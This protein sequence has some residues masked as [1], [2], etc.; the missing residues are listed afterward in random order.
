MDHTESADAAAQPEPAAPV[1]EPKRSLLASLFG[2]WDPPPWVRWLWGRKF[3]VAGVLA[4]LALVGYGAWWWATRP[5]PVIPNALDVTLT[6]PGKTDYDHDEIRVRPL[7]VHFSGSAAPLADVEGEAQG[8]TLEPFLDGSFRWEDDHTIVFRPAKDWPVGQHYTVTLDP[9][10]TVAETV[11]LAPF[12]L[13]FDTAPFVVEAGTAEFYQDP[14]DAALKKSVWELRFSHPVDAAKFESALRVRL[15]DG[16][17]RVLPPP[18][19][20]TQYNARKLNAWVHSAPLELPPNGGEAHLDVGQGITSALGGPGSTGELSMKVD[21][22]ALYSVSVDDLSPTLVEEPGKEPIQVI[23]LGFNMAMKDREVVGATRAWLLPEKNPKLKDNE[24]T[25][26]YGWS[27]DEVDEA[28][29][30]ASMPLELKADPAE[31]EWTEIH[32]FKYQAPVG[33]RLYVRVNQ[34]L[35]SFGGFI[36]GKP[37]AGVRVVPEFPRMLNFVGEGALLSLRGERRVTVVARNMPKARLEIGRVLPEQLHHLVQFNEGSYGNPELWSIGEDSLVERMEKRIVLPGGDP[38][39]TLYE[40]VDLGEFFTG[41][42]HGVFLLSLRTLSDHEAEQSPDWTIGNDAGETMDARLVVLTDLGIVVKKTLDGSREVFVQ[43]LA[44]GTPVAGARVRVLARNGET[45]AASDTDAMGRASLPNLDGFQREKVAVAISVVAGE[46]LSFLPLHKYDRALDFSRFDIG[47]DANEIDAGTLKAHLFSDRGLYRPGDTVNIGFIVRAADWNRPLAGIPLEVEFSDPRGSVVKRQRVSLD[48]TGFD[49]FSHAP[50]EGAPSGTWQATLYLIGEEDSRTMIGAT[51][52]QIREFLPDTMRVRTTL[53]ASASEGWVKPDGMSATVAVENLFGT[54]AQQ[55]RVEA[56]LLLRPAFPSFARWPGWRF[57][58]PLS[59]NDGVNEPLSEGE[60]DEAGN[61]VFDLGL[62]NYARATYQLSFLARAFEPGS[63]RSVAAQTGTLV[64]SNDYLVG[65]QGEDA[66]YH[67]QRGAKRALQLVSI[68]PDAQPVAVEGLR[69][70]LIARYYVS[71]LTRQDSGLYRYVSQ[72]RK[73][74]VSDTP[75]PAQA[76]EQPLVLKTDEPGDYFVEIRDARDTVVN[77]LYYVVAGDANVTRSLERNA[78]LAL[79]LSQPDYPAGGEIEIGI[80]APYTGSGLITI[81]RDR[82]YAHTWFRATTTSSVQKIR[83]PDDFEGSG[84]VNVQF[85]RDPGSEE[86][87]MS[88][89]SYAVA[90][91]SVDR[92]RRTLPLEFTVPAVSKPGAEITLALKTQGRARVV[93]FAIDEGILQVARYQLADP[94]DHFFRKKMLDVETSQIL[95]LILPEFSRLVASAAPGG[96][97]EG[98]LGK[99]LN[100]FTRKSETPAVWWSGLTDVDG[101]H[102][103]RFRMPDHFNGQ[104]RVMA[105]AVSSERIGIETG[106]ALVRGDF[107]LTPTV[108]THVAPGDEFELPVGVA[109]TA[110]GTDGSAMDVAVQVEL[111]AT[112]ALVGDGPR[113]LSLKPGQEGKISI[114]L[115]AGEGLGAAP[116]TIIASSGERSVRRRIELSLRPAIVG[117]SDLRL[118]RADRRVELKELRTMYPERS[119]RLLSA[120]TSP[121]V[122][123]DGLVAYLQDYPHLCTEQL[124][125]Q[126]VPALVYRARPEFGEIRGSGSPLDLIDVLRA[127][128]NGEG[129]I[130]LWLATPDVDPFISAW[131]GFYLVEARERGVPVPDDLLNSVNRYLAGMAADAA[132]TQVHELRARALATYLLIRQ[133]QTATH[134]LSAVHEQLKRDYPD[135]WKE[136]SIGMLLAASYQLLQQAR[137]AKELAQGGLAR[138]GAA[139]APKFQGFRYYHDAGI[140]TAWVVYLAHKHFP[141][142]AERVRVR[143]IE[144][145]LWPLQHEQYSTLYSALTV[146]ALDAYTSAQQAVGLPQLA[147]LGG[148]GVERQ[149]GEAFGVLRRAAFSASDQMLAVTP[150]EATPAWYVLAQTGY[151]QAAPKAV[152]GQ[153]IEVLRDY[154][155]EDGKPL[156]AAALGQEITVRLR[157]RAL[158]P[159]AIDSIAVVDLLPGGFEPV[160]QMPPAP[161]DSGEVDEEDSEDGES[162]PPVPTL[163]LPGS[164]LWTEHVEQREDR[165]VV[166]ASAGPQIAEFRYKVKPSNP[167]SFVIPPAYAES[168]YER[169][170]YAQGGPAGTIEVK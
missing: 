25:I 153:G 125:S 109:N 154:L 118:G 7:R 143:A 5:P 157:L 149:I 68:G 152:Q 77:K 100:P 96:D 106:K 2:R 95:D 142:E 34:G 132:L 59:R 13:G 111:P 1:A 147:A 53:S 161:A 145:L 61:A 101:E 50:S 138:V 55:R 37:A 44:N 84:Y 170:I 162:A 116:V 45:L 104:L 42:R 114:R 127:R 133:G 81:E 23:V 63:G 6:A 28:L 97:G 151:D 119:Q 47:G 32:S 24:Q 79:S 49:A 144:N 155:G 164:S 39:K 57:H 168:M 12:E 115:R 137:P 167:G 72:E 105:V 129:G 35:K 148:D 56:T 78:E 117:R 51:T 91:F 166:Y 3:K 14:Q 36:L 48:A 121:F 21:L 71:I 92:G 11:V 52:V 146:L 140:D 33:R 88:P 82:V 76:G 16:A 126:A 158:G 4:V 19:L 89:L 159:D 8:I 27:E 26:P 80:R 156:T 136:D 66:L 107:V 130:G 74:T 73:R 94:L 120:S 69:V 31:R 60:T 70:V 87:Y 103:F 110:E 41:G 93:A 139:Q 64:S 165:V 134:L 160:V 108:P 124:L 62:Q 122:A 85:I 83:I 163:A 86:I 10:K 58:D 150:P 169:G 9:K 29:L 102:S 128:Q 141:Q 15:F 67:V 135:A 65:I 113:P 18:V 123:A 54:P 75:L 38:A 131:A 20:S 46:D 43:S 40:G 17:G 112:L 22:P 30:K 90:P 98:E 99:H